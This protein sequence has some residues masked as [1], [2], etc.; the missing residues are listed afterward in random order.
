[1]LSYDTELRK[2]QARLMNEGSSFGVAL[3]A[4]TKDPETRERAFVTPLLLQVVSAS[5]SGSAGSG[6]WPAPPPQPL[7]LTDG[8]RPD[9]QKKKKSAKK[10]GAGNGGQQ[11]GGKGGGK[12]DGKGAGKGTAGVKREF[13]STMEQNLHTR[14]SDGREICFKFQ[15]GTCTGECKRVHVCRLCLGTHPSKTCPRGPR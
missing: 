1:M 7:A 6:F 8:S 9:P 3:V 12:G 4:A 5:S 13:K 11:G 14:T 15:R 10:G 2:H